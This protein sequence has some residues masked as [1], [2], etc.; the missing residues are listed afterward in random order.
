MNLIVL[1][2]PV[3]FAL[4][5]V[6]VF[7]AWR[8]EKST[9]RLSDAVNDLSCG[10]LE[11]VAGVF[12]K[13]A[14]FA[15]Y[16]F[17]FERYRLLD[18]PSSSPLAWLL[19]W[20]GVDFFY[21]WFHRMSHEVNAGWAAHIVH[22]QSED[23]NLAVALRQ[24]VFQGAMSW[25]FYLPLALAG[26]PPAMFLAVSALNTLYQFWIHTRLIGKL[27][28]LEWVLNTPSHHRVHHGRNPKYIDRNHAGSLIIWD[29]MFG[30]FQEEEEEPVYGI[31]KPLASF[32]PVWA[33]FHYWAE[34][35]RTAKGAARPLDRWRVFWKPP[36]WRPADLGGYERAPEVD[37]ASYRKYDPEVPRRAGLYVFA[38]FVLV[39]LVAS[40]FL[41]QQAA[42]GTA[43]RVALALF[44]GVSVLCL[45]GLLDRR[46]WAVTAEL[47]RLAA[48]AGLAFWLLP[49]TAFALT[50]LGS[51]VSA[52]W[53]PREGHLIGARGVS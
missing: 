24:S 47:G 15:G 10:I 22:H 6:E 39:N 12:L 8:E 41:H 17:V 31:T 53:L 11:Q 27:G 19:C 20:L 7:W 34:L 43:P 14:V 9:Y 45:G 50:A 13:T 46:G 21:Y 3:F 42:L 44:I 48:G 23:M 5:A 32:N 40:Y 33:N 49:P 36:G 37:A 35:L 2:I 51:L 1:A 52:A 25:V 16:L 4:I 28:P 38:Q 26:F 18:I 30:T 29:R